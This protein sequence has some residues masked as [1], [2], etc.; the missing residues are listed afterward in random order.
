MEKVF[1]KFSSFAESEKADREYY[2]KLSWGERL[3]ILLELNA[4]YR[5]GFGEA[6][7]RFARVYRIVQRP[8]R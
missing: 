7:E 8:R 5:E 3:E 4:R 6:A 1:R 2:A